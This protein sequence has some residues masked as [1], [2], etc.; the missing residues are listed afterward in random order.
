MFFSPCENEKPF[1]SLMERRC[2]PFTQPLNHNHDWEQDPLYSGQCP[3]LHKE[4]TAASPTIIINIMWWLFLA[5]SSSPPRHSISLTLRTICFLIHKWM[6]SMSHGFERIPRGGW[7]VVVGRE[8]SGSQTDNVRC[9]RG[10]WR[11]PA[12]AVTLPPCRCGTR[13]S[14]G[15]A[16]QWQQGFGAVR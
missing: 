2:V 1:H 11:G 14:W 6:G 4:G 8:L 15:V 3:A 10:E 13:G 12:D 7:G 9:Q 16:G 5:T